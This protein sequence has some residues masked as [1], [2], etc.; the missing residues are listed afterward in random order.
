MLVIRPETYAGV[1][2]HCCETWRLSRKQDGLSRSG[3]YTF[4]ANNCYVRSTLPH[5][6]LPL[7]YT[8]GGVTCNSYPV[9]ILLL[10][11]PTVERRP[12]W[13]LSPS[14]TH[15]TNSPVIQVRGPSRS[16][17]YLPS[18]LYALRTPSV[19]VN[20]IDLFELSLLTNLRYTDLLLRLPALASNVYISQ[21]PEFS[22]PHFHGHWLAPGSYP[23]VD[24]VFVCLAKFSLRWKMMKMSRLLITCP[25]WTVA[26]TWSVLP[27]RVLQLRTHITHPEPFVIISQRKHRESPHLLSSD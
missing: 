9:L 26:V 23:N 3:Y 7:A 19:I 27:C 5:V 10:R 17:T 16:D 18:A 8:V 2:S 14:P 20:I 4:P 21:V 11:S 1:N 22:S 12:A 25:V 13:T 15:H 24:T 6:Y